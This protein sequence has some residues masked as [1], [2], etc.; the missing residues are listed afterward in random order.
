[1]FSKKWH[2][3]FLENLTV[4]H[5]DLFESEPDIGG[6]ED[7]ERRDSAMLAQW[8]GDFTGSESASTREYLEFI[9]NSLHSHKKLTPSDKQ[10]FFIGND[11]SK[12]IISGISYYLQDDLLDCVKQID[13]W[14]TNWGIPH[15]KYPKLYVAGGSAFYLAMNKDTSKSGILNDFDFKIDVSKLPPPMA[16]EFKK[17]L[18]LFLVEGVTQK[19]L[20][21][22]FKKIHLPLAVAGDAPRSPN[23]LTLWRIPIIGYLISK[24]H[25]DELTK[26]MLELYG[27]TY[28]GWDPSMNLI[29]WVFEQDN[30]GISLWRDKDMEPSFRW[31]E[32]EFGDDYSLFSF[33]VFTEKQKKTLEGQGGRGPVL[34]AGVV[35]I[36][37]CNKSVLHTEEILIDETLNVSF[38]EDGFITYTTT[39][40]GIKKIIN[41]KQYVETV[42]SIS[43]LS[44]EHTI[45][46]IRQMW[47]V[48]EEDK[49]N[50]EMYIVF[51]RGRVAIKDAKKNLPMWWNR[52]KKLY[53]DVSR[54]INGI[55]EMIEK[56]PK[57]IDIYLKI[58]NHIMD[59]IKEAVELY[60]GVVGGQK[61]LRLGQGEEKV[62]I[63]TYVLQVEQLNG[64]QPMNEDIE[65]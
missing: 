49:S 14:V 24:A 20:E 41:R 59:F 38:S 31:R 42:R 37:L 23:D 28:D 8:I 35:D 18:Q 54:L 34:A 6:E 33:D 57:N 65:R 56:D 19:C 17:K 46:D 43:Y 11:L 48:K 45:F 62:N 44:I 50:C 2:P 39:V 64:P 21:D 32:G 5:D 40:D 10:A 60:N 61:A 22:M 47:F 26:K 29:N 51:L 27:I 13:T 12:M 25:G 9:K 7:I 53:K 52:I 3:T 63:D 55:K 1:M 16:E 15:D 30:I 4:L 58:L 36:V